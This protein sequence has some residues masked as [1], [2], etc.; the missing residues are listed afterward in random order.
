MTAGPG[1]EALDELY[2]RAE[3]LQALYW[4]HGERL[5][6]EATAANLASFLGV[7]PVVVGEYMKRLAGE[8][9]LDPAGSDG[10]VRYRLT[11]LGL[12][13]GG[14]SFSDEFAELTKPAHGEC[15]PGCWC[16]DPRHV[17]EECPSRSA[18]FD[19]G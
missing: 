16:R 17:G 18:V 19:G 7:D 3:I 12:T 6:T 5:A 10:G 1:P 15:G 8:G 2:W 4:M 14:R 9:Y 13:E 11:A